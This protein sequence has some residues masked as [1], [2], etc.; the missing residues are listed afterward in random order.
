MLT[1]WRQW[2]KW[3]FYGEGWVIELIELNY[4]MSAWNEEECQIILEILCHMADSL[5]PRFCTLLV[6]VL[7]SFVCQ[8]P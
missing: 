3:G 8:G 2:D 5:K 1:N 7:K 4:A 6:N